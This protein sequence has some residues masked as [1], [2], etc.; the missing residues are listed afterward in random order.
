MSGLKKIAT[1]TALK[2]LLKLLPQ[3]SP[4]E[5]IDAYRASLA[6][7]CYT[8]CNK[9]S[10]GVPS[11]EDVD[12]FMQE[13]DSMSHPQR[14][15]YVHEGVNDQII[16]MFTALERHDLSLASHKKMGRDPAG[17]RADVGFTLDIRHSNIPG[18]GEGLFLRTENARSLPPGTVLALY[19]GLVHLKEHLKKIEHFQSLLPDDD[20]L[21]MARL[22]ESI[23]DGR[24]ADRVVQNQYALAHKINH[25]GEQKP[26]V[27]Q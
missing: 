11:P 23:I 26:N 6:L 3:E 12:K 1:S 16:S 9:S 17:L 21:L 13:V 24:T 18:A 20:F 5:K 22:D 7:K 4:R 10:A 25:S 15:K 27:M 2:K 19:P 14:A 8:V